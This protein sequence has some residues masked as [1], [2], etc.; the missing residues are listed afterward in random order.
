MSDIRKSKADLL[1]RA[2]M[3]IHKTTKLKKY[4][5]VEEVYDESHTCDGRSGGRKREGDVLRFPKDLLKMIPVPHFLASFVV[6]A[7]G[8]SDGVFG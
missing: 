7:G 4:Q 2:K 3:G 8:E 1:S 6:W 5:V